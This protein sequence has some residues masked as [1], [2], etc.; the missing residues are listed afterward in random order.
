MPIAK[1][2]LQIL[3]V[4]K[5]LQCVRDGNKEQV[6]KLTINGCPHLINFNDPAEGLTALIVAA[7]TNDDGM[8]DFLLGLGAHPDVMDLKGRTAAMWA[9][10]YGNVECLEKLIGAGANMLLNDLEGKGNLF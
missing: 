7:K 6:E 8:T 10:E 2:R 9:V 5:L 4:C 3:Q 1:T